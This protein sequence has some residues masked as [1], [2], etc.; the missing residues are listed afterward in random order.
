MTID[1]ETLM[2]YTDGELD[3]LTRRRVE[4]AITADPALAR[5]VEADRALRAMI[6]GHF[7]PIADEAVPE[8]L[9]ALL[10]TNVVEIADRRGRRRPARSWFVNAA[11]IAA[12]LVVGVLVGRGIADGDAGPV[13][14]RN[15]VTVAQGALAEAL[16]TQLASA[17]PANAATRI[18]I[19]F[20]N[21]DGRYCRTFR[22]SG[23]D[24][25]AC[26][27][28]Q[29]WQIRHMASGTGGGATEY[30]QAASADPAILAAAQAM[31]AGAP[32]DAAGEKAARDQAWR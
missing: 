20:R 28:P 15:G 3:E 19:T 23:L 5:Q 11:A 8:K 17:Q 7:A 16:D 31:M 2:A 21:G 26:R 25:V 1:R 12:T 30:R 9:S 14:T 6:A 29:G 18:G 32:L 4:Q 10:Q 13:G 22:G 24:G 27:D